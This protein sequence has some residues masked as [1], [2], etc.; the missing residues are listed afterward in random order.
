[1]DTQTWINCVE[2]IWCCVPGF[3]APAHWICSDGGSLGH[4]SDHRNRNQPSSKFRSCSGQFSQWQMESTC[5]RVSLTPLS[6]KL[7]TL[8]Q[9][10]SFHCHRYEC[11]QFL[12]IQLLQCSWF[13]REDEFGGLLR[14]WENLLTLFWYTSECKMCQFIL[15]ITNSNMKI[16]CSHMV[17]FFGDIRVQLQ[18]ISVNPSY[19]H[20][21][22]LALV[23]KK[24][25][26]YW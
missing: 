5:K 20:C 1:M 6:T 17:S 18:P 2:F 7:D 21:H 19:L 14:R 26:T 3:G 4:H 9:F 8:L 23:A 16:H 10:I 24:E 22:S 25:N 15:I 11:F 12:W 13:S